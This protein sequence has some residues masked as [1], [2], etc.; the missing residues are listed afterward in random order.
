MHD[1]RR[2]PMVQPERYRELRLA[3]L[4]LT[5]VVLL[6]GLTACDDRP[7]SVGDCVGGVVCNTSNPCTTGNTVCG[8]DGTTHCVV[9]EVLE[10]CGEQ[11]PDQMCLAGVICST[12]N[13]CTTGNTVCDVDG[14]SICV[15]VERLADCHY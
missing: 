13:P 9:V 12:G 1:C 5:I 10:N 8:A 6:L 15:A 3:G 11:P 2:L 4:L 14:N 7:R